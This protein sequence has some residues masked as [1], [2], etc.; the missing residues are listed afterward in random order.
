MNPE[1][2]D[3]VSIR[4]HGKILLTGEYAVL[5][6]AL[7]LALPVCYGQTLDVAPGESGLLRWTSRD[8]AGQIW[9]EAAFILPG[10]TLLSAS[11]EPTAQRLQQMLY[12]C[13]RQN[14][15][16]LADTQ[17]RQIYTRTDFPRAWGLGTSSTLIAALA[18]WAGADPYQVL[19]ETLGG[20]GYDI[21]C[22]FA[23]GPLLYWLEGDTP[24]VEP[25][26][27][28]PPFAGHLF[29]VFLGK[30]QDSRAGIRHFR[31]H[32]KHDTG[33]IEAISELTRRCLVAGTL[34]DFSAVLLEH[35]RLIGQA[36]DLPRAQDLYFP[37]FP[38]VVKSLGAWGGDFVLAASD[39][40][41]VQGYFRK[42][43]FEVCIPFREMRLKRPPG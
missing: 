3:T 13:R 7:A 14:P 34:A 11:D 16:F 20:S 41:D 35:E 32:A 19:F 4:A 28:E 17:G 33:M 5:D 36:L 27:F 40:G 1:I 30:K 31:E 43:G 25:T 39:A 42:K 24:Q 21:A 18:R 6:G 22:A 12:V 9:F 38:G 29:F 26:A 23:D 2:P 37:D 10:L 8:E 15:R